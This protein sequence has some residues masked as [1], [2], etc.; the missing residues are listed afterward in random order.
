MGGELNDN[1]PNTINDATVSTNANIL[2]WTTNFTDIT[3]EPFTQDSAPC[4]P[5]NFEVSVA[6][7]LDYF[8]LLFKPE[9]FRDIKDHTHNYAIFKQEEIWRNR[10]KHGYVYCVWQETKVEELK[11]LFGIN[12]SVGLILLPQYKLYWCQ[13]DFTGNSWVKNPMT[14][15]RYQKLTQYMHLSDRANEPAQNSADYDKLQKIDLVL[16]MVWYSF[17]ESYKPGKNQ[18]IDEVMIALRVDLFIYNI[19]L[20]NQSRE[21]LR[22]GCAVMLVQHICFNLI[23]ILVNRKTLSVVLDMMWWW[24]YV[25]YCNETIQVNK[26]RLPEGICKPGR[27]TCGVYKSY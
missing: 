25:A 16:N 2:N 15:R 23:C 9:I 4:S 12:I 6:T 24:S 13:N 11:V 5:E 3:I 19:Y 18:T 26:K 20:P 17:A 10:N 27:I 22:Y 7:A 8:K 21:E 14:C 1:G